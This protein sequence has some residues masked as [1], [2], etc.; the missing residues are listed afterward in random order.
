[1]QDF[2]PHKELCAWNY[3]VYY[4]LLRRGIAWAM[5]KEK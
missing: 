3:D 5:R 2:Y 1:M 4:D